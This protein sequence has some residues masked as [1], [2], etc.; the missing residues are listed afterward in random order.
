MCCIIDPGYEKQKI[1]DFISAQQLEVQGILLTHGHIDH[2]GAADC[3]PVPVF[4]HEADRQIFLNNFTSG[5]ASYNLPNPYDPGELDIRWISD[6]NEMNIGSIKVQIVT[7]P[8]HSPGGL[9]FKINNRLFTGDTLFYHTVGR[10]IYTDGN[11]EELKNSILKIIN[12]FSSG[13]QVFPAHGRPTTIGEEK[14]HNSYYL[15]WSSHQ[16][17]LETYEAVKE[18]E[19]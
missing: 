13:T 12:T 1:I 10:W 18:Q 17:L 8:G 16:E 2:I 19:S 9:C 14:Q 5:F 15:Y 3:F 4:V 7:S 6:E 11:Q